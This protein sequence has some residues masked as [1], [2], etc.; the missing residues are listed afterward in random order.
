MEGGATASHHELS[1]IAEQHQPLWNGTGSYG[2]VSKDEQD[3]VMVKD[4]QE[5]G[6]EKQQ[7]TDTKTVEMQAKSGMPMLIPGL[8]GV[9][10][11][12]GVQASDGMDVDDIP[13]PALDK[14]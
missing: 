11:G 8:G 6:A 13:V 12:G 1:G 9:V 10:S 2:D 4:E 7:G 3:V 5:S 14:S